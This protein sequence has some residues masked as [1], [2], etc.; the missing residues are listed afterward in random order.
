MIVADHDL[1]H[2]QIVVDSGWLSPDVEN[3]V[4]F[5]RRAL[6]AGSGGRPAFQLGQACPHL[7]VVLGVQELP[8]IEDRPREVLEPIL[9]DV[10]QAQQD[11]RSLL[12]L[13]PGFF[14][15]A[16]RLLGIECF[17]PAQQVR[18]EWKRSSSR[19]TSACS[20]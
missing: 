6:R 4:V 18:K 8:Q 19:A 3:A 10:R 15:Q 11:R 16:D 14:Q 20:T 5:L 1:D 7:R 13:G 12:S 17:G 2:V 9:V